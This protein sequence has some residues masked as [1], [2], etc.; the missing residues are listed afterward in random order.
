M[1]NDK[2]RS[3]QYGDLVVE[4]ICQNRVVQADAVSAC[5]SLNKR[6]EVPQVG[7][8]VEVIGPYVL[9]MEHGRNEIHPVKL[10]LA[11]CKLT[12]RPRRL[13]PQRLGSLP[14]WR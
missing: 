1:L 9:D 8:H 12:P 2:N 7:A 5:E 6:W 10:N 11:T 14:S 3:A 4:I 13:S